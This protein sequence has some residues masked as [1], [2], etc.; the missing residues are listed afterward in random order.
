MD[1]RR[2]LRS[3]L[4]LGAVAP[5]LPFLPA[6][7]EWKPGSGLYRGAAKVYPL[8]DA[9]LISRETA[10]GHMMRDLKRSL[11]DLFINGPKTLGPMKVTRWK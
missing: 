2:F 1:R 8:Y 5:L 3:A 6:P 7:L 10:Y 9:G 4:A 11:N